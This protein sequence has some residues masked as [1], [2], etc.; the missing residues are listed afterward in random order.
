MKVSV[1]SIVSNF[2]N[3][4]SVLEIIPTIVNVPIAKP[5]M[6]INDCTFLVLLVSREEVKQVCKVDVMKVSTKDGGCR[7]KNISVDGKTRRRRQGGGDRAMNYGMESTSTRLVLA[8]HHE[9]SEAR[10]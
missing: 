4:N 2:V 3:K 5:I 10:W 9:E 8:C 6:P 1:I 7:L